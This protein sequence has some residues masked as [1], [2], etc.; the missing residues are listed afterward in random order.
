MT[1]EYFR[2]PTACSRDDPHPKYY[3]DGTPI[4]ADVLASFVDEA[5]ATARLIQ[6]TKEGHLILAHRDHGSEDGWVHPHF[7]RDDLDAAVG[8]VP[9]IFYSLNCT[10]G[11]FAESTT[12]EFFGEKALR[13]PGEAP[14]VIGASE[15]SNTWLNNHLMRALFDGMFGG[16]IPT[17]PGTSA[18]YPI[19]FNR[20]GDL[21]NYAKTYLP[22]ASSDRATIR[23]HLEIYHVLGDPSLELWRQASRTLQLTAAL[24]PAGLDVRLSDCPAGTMV[25]IWYDGRLMKRV[26]MTST[27]L[28]LPSSALLPAPPPAAPLPTI[29]ISAN[30]DS[31]VANGANTIGI[32]VTDSGGGPI[33][34]TTTRGTFAGGPSAN[35]TVR[36]GLAWVANNPK[37]HSDMELIRLEN[38]RKTY[39]VG[40]VDVPVFYMNYA[41]D[42]LASGQRAD[43]ERT[44]SGQTGAEAISSSNLPFSESDQ[45]ETA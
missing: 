41:L 37:G 13:L 17:F 5:T 14:S 2:H 19:R 42:P 16:M 18:S 33:A 40:E 1:P 10:T 26:A 7:T 36:Y 9:S 45:K 28:V 29:G 35:R 8:P 32:T 27:R 4:P 25:T 43:N 23:D 20:L 15:L 6:S 21:L 30:L 44:I 39:S 31:V 12:A 11:A 3:N 38:I 34:V 24:T 22:L